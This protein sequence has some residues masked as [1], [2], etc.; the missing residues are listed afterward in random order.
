GL[1]GGEDQGGALGLL[2]DLGHGEGLAR[3][4]DAE[5]D[6][7]ALALPRLGDELGD[8][9][10]LVAGGGVFRLQPEGDAFAL[11]RTVGAVGRPALRRAGRLLRRQA[12]AGD[13]REHRHVRRLRRPPGRAALVVAQEG[14]GRLGQL[15]GDVD[16][17]L[18]AGG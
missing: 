6:L 17:L 4:G 15:A 10:G 3:A 13:R 9:G 11:V 7:V 8:G 18:R 16:R 12:R 5:Q 14:G 1:V 2:D